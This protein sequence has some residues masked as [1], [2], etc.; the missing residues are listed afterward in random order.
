MP[1]VHHTR[2][3][4]NGI[5]LHCA[6]AGSGPLV[7]LLHGFPEDWRCWEPVIPHLVAAGYRVVAPDLRGYG[8]SDKP[9]SGYDLETLTDDVRG[10]ASHFLQDEGPAGPSGRRVR[11][12][13]HDW[14]GAVTWAFAYRHPD[15]LARAAI[16]NA[17]HPWLFARRLV[18]GGQLRRSWYMG[19]FQLPAL[20]EA[21]LARGGLEWAWESW[22]ATAGAIPAA[23]QARLRQ[24][25]LR[26][27]ALR[28]ALAWYRTAFRRGPLALRPCA[29]VTDAELLVLWGER[30]GCLGAELLRG[31][32][33]HTNN[34]RIVRYPDAGHWLQR[35]E[36]GAVSN[37]LARFL[38]P[39]G[40]P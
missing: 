36:V 27:G 15:I 14:G 12:V 35:E 2:V 11:L 31:L 20:P 13:G 30:D 28:G 26:P 4:S 38:E 29:G 9:P 23:D 33:R 5:D 19:F 17:P 21:W 39:A 1:P 25:M 37:E 8:A 32:E 24:S 22:G 7:L 18:S 10:L 16:L 34:L 3:R 6:V 40:R